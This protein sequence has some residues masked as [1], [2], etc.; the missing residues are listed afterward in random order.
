[1][2]MSSD[3]LLQIVIASGNKNKIRELQA[4]ATGYNIKLS[5][6]SEIK[7]ELNLGEVPEVEETSPDYLGNARLKAEAYAQWSGI[8]ALGDDSGLEV[9]ALDGRPG[10]LSARYGGPGLDDTGRWQRLL[11]EVRELE[12]SKSD[13]SRRAFFRCVLVLS[14]PGGQELS[15]EG[16]LE[17]ELLKKPRGDAGFGYDPV[18]LIDCLGKTLAEV[19][20]SLVC[21]QGFRARAARKLFDQLQ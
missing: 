13:L 4:V 12:A 11:A 3:T 17:G 18:V 7:E 16:I 6:P 2:P 10:V 19:D 15:T 1:M 20:F 21:E 14:F 5:S 9:E 8:P